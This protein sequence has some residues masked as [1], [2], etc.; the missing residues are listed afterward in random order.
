MNVTHPAPT[1]DSLMLT[2]KILW[3]G[4]VFSQITL[5]G[6]GYF[7]TSQHPS[8][9]PEVTNAAELAD[10]LFFKIFSAAAVICLV[11]SRYLPG[12]LFKSSLAQFPSH[13]QGEEKD[14]FIIQKYFPGFIVGMALLESICIFGFLLFNY[15]KIFPVFLG[16]FIF[17][18]LN[19]LIRFPVKHV[20]LKT[21]EDLLN[22][23]KN[24]K[25]Y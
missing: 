24:L 9:F 1:S 23:H 17:S 10:T 7:V 3:I 19:A 25:V 4:L 13:L 22:P 5:L 14:V 16:F 6:L 15:Y 12:F 2:M 20:I 18:C 8:Q 21:A 11:L